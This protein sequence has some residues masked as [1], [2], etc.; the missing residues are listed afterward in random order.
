MLPSRGAAAAAA[1]ATAAAAAASERGA[2][3]YCMAAIC[4]TRRLWQRG[5]SPPA[6]KTAAS[7][8]TGDFIRTT[9]NASSASNAGGVVRR[10][11]RCRSS[12]SSRSC[13]SH[14]WFSVLRD[15]QP[16]QRV[17]AELA[18]A[19]A[20]E[21]D[22]NKSSSENLQDL[23][24][25]HDEFYR[26]SFHEED[27]SCPNNYANISSNRSSSI[28][29]G[30]NNSRSR[31][32]ANSNL[33]REESDGDPPIQV[34]AEIVLSR[35]Q[36]EMLA[37]EEATA[38]AA[39][40][41]DRQQRFLHSVTAA[42]T[43]EGGLRTALQQSFEALLPPHVA[44]A[45]DEADGFVWSEADDAS[46]TPAQRFYRDN[47]E[48]LLQ[49]AEQYLRGKQA[50]A[51]AAAAGGDAAAAEEEEWDDAAKTVEED[52]KAYFNPVYKQPKGFR[53]PVA[54]APESAAA[55]TPPVYATLQQ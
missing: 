13:G 54:D 23:E 10:W 38:A 16:L 24:E 34:H 42:E 18:A 22:S 3:G 15:P 53:W 35:E 55:S 28:S 36:Q 33:E 39:S 43:T 49:R 29:S 46:L 1:A 30:N 47:R 41:A 26:S 5:D 45:A 12:N 52:W 4:S 7:A 19:E 25:G 48:L 17:L 40:A 27:E 50:A 11:C 21:Q 51:A 14:R 2:P 6:A 31:P 8:A 32:G 44:A 37:A 9:R 20:V